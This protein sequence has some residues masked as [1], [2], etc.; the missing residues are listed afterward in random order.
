MSFTPDIFAT[1]SMTLTH[2]NGTVVAQHLLCQLDTVNLPWNM[3][4][5]GMVPTDWYDLYSVGWDTPVPLRSDYFV[6]ETT[7]TKYS[8]FSEVF[9]SLGTVQCRVTKYSGTTP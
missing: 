4:V 7:G 1:N 8:M 9:V 2:S 6:D 5:Q 3:E